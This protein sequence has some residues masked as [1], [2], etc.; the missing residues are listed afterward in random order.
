M[1]LK[2]SVAIVTG[3][4]RGI[5][6]AISAALL[7]SKAKVHF[8]DINV[9]EGKKVENEF[10]NIYGK[11]M[12]KF[13]KCDVTNDQELHGAISDAVKQHGRL[14]ILCN[15][16][17]VGPNCDMRHIVDTNLTAVM[18]GTT[19]A[20]QYMDNTKGGHGGHIINMSSI[21]GL[22]F[23]PAANCAY[24]AT[25]H[26][27]VGFTRSFA[28]VTINVGVRLNCICPSVIETDMI[29][30]TVESDPSLKP[31]IDAIGMQSVDIVAK[32]FL[33]LLEDETKNGEA[34][35]I[36]TQNGIDYHIFSKEKIPV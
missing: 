16:A 23:I 29:K 26:G 22:C 20:L 35:R 15:N 14:D 7:Q 12:V 1:N 36:T 19:I 4:A 33:Q 21:G 31:Q 3:G 32:G 11:G 27:I 5:G 13:V 10:E 25:K 9:K 30:E 24:N 34:M 2:G 6:K 28:Q 8:L 17:G 18:R